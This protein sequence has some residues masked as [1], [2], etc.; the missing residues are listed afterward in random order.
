VLEEN[1]R[2]LRR[3]VFSF[4]FAGL[5]LLTEIVSW[6]IDLAVRVD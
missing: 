1:G 2:G 5:M 3:V 6:A 4:R